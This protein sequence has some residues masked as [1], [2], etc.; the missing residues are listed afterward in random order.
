MK[1]KDGFKLREVCG[2]TV[3]MAEGANMVNFSKIIRLNNSAA[4]VWKAVQ[5]KEFTEDDIANIL[6]ES[7]E[8]DRATALADAKTLCNSLKENQVITE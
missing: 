4:L 7:Y 8:I 2:E 6:C 3:V 1:I 5:G